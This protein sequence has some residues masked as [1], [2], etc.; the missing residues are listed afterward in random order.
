MLSNKKHVTKK[1]KSTILNNNFIYNI[2][3]IDVVNSIVEV[4]DVVSLI[5]SFAC[6]E[7]NSFGNSFVVLVI[8]SL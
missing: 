8:T 3:P 4:E 7:V 2:L 5:N 6:V 1:Q